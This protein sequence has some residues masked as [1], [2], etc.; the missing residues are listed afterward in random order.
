MAQPPN[1]TLPHYFCCMI[2]KLLEPRCKKSLVCIRYYLLKGSKGSFLL[3]A[4]Q[5]VDLVAPEASSY[6]SIEVWE[7][8]G[9]W[10][11]AMAVQAAPAPLYGRHQR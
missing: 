5:E 10:W 2:F 4:R 3:V 8:E 1:Y 9:C 11:V 7:Q 6:S